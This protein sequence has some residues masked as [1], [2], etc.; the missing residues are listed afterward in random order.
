MADYDFLS[1]S[2]GTGDSSLMHITAARATGSTTLTVDTVSRVPAKFIATSGV[3]LSTGLLNPST[4]TNFKGHTSAGSLQID[5]FEPGS[6]D[7]GNAIGDV[8][9]IKPNTGWANRVASFVKNASGVGTVENLFVSALTAVS[10]TISGSINAVSA[11]ISGNVSIGGSLAVT[12]TSRITAVVIT[13][14]ATITPT[15][16]VYDVTALAVTANVV[17]PSFAAV[18]GMSAVVRIKDNGTAQ[19]LS[20]AAGYVDVSGIGLPTATIA[21]KLLTIG[22]MYNSATSKWEVQGINQQA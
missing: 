17:I 11:A 7:N 20:F 2:D 16:Q 10:A 9:I 12:G 5:G 13:S 22:V 19:G 1:V 14:A 3:L 15:S 21:N 18:N 6:T 4:V 8:I